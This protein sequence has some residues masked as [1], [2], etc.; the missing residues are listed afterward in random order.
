M[1]D[2][3]NELLD[4]FC[5]EVTNS[6]L[7]TSETD[8]EDFEASFSGDLFDTT[9]EISDSQDE[10][11]T[12]SDLSE[13]Y[14]EAFSNRIDEMSLDE[15]YAAKDEIKALQQDTYGLDEY[16]KEQLQ[17]MKD[18][19]DAIRDTDDNNDG[20]GDEEQIRVLKLRRH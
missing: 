2:S 12:V 19:I 5:D 15:L 3:Y 7:E 16:N 1:N 14:E 11:P 6:V 17:D 8:F 9:K 20:D 4:D 18:Y 13:N 10:L